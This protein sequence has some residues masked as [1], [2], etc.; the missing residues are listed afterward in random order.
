V[1]AQSQQSTAAGWHGMEGNHISVLEQSG[2]E[3]TLGCHI[4][5]PQGQVV[6][7]GCTEK[8]LGHG[9]RGVEEERAWLAPGE[10]TARVGHLSPL[11]DFTLP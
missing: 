5:L 7:K 4:V 2:T 9:K 10:V 3:L 1:L 8:G 6:S 11:L